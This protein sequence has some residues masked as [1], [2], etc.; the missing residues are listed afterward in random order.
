MATVPDTPS[1]PSRP[2]KETDLGYLKLSFCGVADYDS[3]GEFIS[4]TGGELC[5]PL[6]MESEGAVQ[7][8]GVGVLLFL[9]G[10]VQP[11]RLE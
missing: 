6:C 3:V 2:P 11:Y 9:D 7:I 5:Y 10:R 4:Y 8:H 1:L